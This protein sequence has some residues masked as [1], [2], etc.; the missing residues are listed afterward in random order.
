M[1]KCDEMLINEMKNLPVFRLYRSLTY[2]YFEVS[3][4]YCFVYSDTIST[5]TCWKFSILGATTVYQKYLTYKERLNQYLDI[6]WEE[7][8]STVENSISVLPIIKSCLY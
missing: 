8:C 5:A 3:H 7:N 4:T 1:N 2:I 6:V